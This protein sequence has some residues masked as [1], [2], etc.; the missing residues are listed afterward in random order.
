[1]LKTEHKM[2]LRYNPG[3]KTMIIVGC[4]CGFVPAMEEDAETAI[5]K[6]LAE[7]QISI[8]GHVKR[9]PLCHKIVHCRSVK[10]MGVHLANVVDRRPCPG[11]FQPVGTARE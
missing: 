7:Y 11:S 1:M 10:Y 3:T 2:K 5:A 9:C 6:H 8:D 4:S